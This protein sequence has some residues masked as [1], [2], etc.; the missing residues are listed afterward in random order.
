MPRKHEPYI[1]TGKCRCA[2]GEENGL[3]GK[4]IRRGDID[5]LLGFEQHTD[6]ALHHVGPLGDG[7]SCHHLG[8]AVVVYAPWHRR[9]IA[10]VGDEGAVD[11]IPIHEK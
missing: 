4:E 6:I 5:I 10:A 9:I 3:G 7:T 11:E 1:H 8:Y 2:H